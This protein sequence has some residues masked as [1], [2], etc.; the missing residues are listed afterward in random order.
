MGDVWHVWRKRNADRLLMGES[1]GNRSLERPG[2]RRDD[3]IKIG[4]KEIGCKGGDWVYLA[5]DTDK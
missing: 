5:Q 2:L 1:E 4:L 3:A